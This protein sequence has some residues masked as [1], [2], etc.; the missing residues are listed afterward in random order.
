MSYQLSYLSPPYISSD[1]DNPVPGINVKLV[2]QSVVQPL[3]KADDEQRSVHTT[4]KKK[5]KPNF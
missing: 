2:N 5:F 1:I 3:S 4:L